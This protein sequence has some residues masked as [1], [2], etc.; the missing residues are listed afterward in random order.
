[1]FLLLVLGFS[2]KGVRVINFVVDFKLI[3]RECFVVY[4][5]L[6]VNLRK[7]EIIFFEIIE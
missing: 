3:S 7:I 4:K 6:G 2:F 1:M 5:C